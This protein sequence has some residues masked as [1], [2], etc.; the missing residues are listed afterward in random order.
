MADVHTKEIRSYNMSRIKG[1]NTRPEM[2]VRKFIH[3]TG[4]GLSTTYFIA[5][6]YKE[7]I[8]I[9]HERQIC[10]LYYFIG[11]RNY[12]CNHLRAT[13]MRMGEPGIFLF[14]NNQFGPRLHNTIFPKRIV[15]EETN[16][17]WFPVSFRVNYSLVCRVYVG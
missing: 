1:K 3:A 9:T 8:F 2:L 6:K 12:S 13:F 17:I 7:Y 14:W 11:N 4:F 5:K 16:W 10:S 15:V